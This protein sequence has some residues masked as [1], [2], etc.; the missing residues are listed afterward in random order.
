MGGMTL[1]LISG[2]WPVFLT[3]F[4]ILFKHKQKEL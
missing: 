3:Y 4:N 1:I 2:N